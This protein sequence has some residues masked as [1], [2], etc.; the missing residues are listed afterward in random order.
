M[1][2]QRTITA[3]LLLAMAA[4]GGPQGAMGTGTRAKDRRTPDDVADRRSRQAAKLDRRAA[5]GR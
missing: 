2:A 5:R 4:I 3:A 1:K